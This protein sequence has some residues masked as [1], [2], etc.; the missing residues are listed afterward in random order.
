[1][2][3]FG[4]MLLAVLASSIFSVTT[5]LAQSNGGLQFT[6]T[7]LG[8]FGGSDSICNAINNKG[9]IVGYIYKNTG[10]N[11]LFVA[12]PST[13]PWSSLSVRALQSRPIALPQPLVWTEESPA[14]LF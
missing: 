1:M 5:L 7:D 10:N 9:Q 14:K 8:T 4:C 6:L 3:R 13:V 12:T 2:R 11:V